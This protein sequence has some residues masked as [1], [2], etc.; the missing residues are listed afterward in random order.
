MELYGGCMVKFSFTGLLV[1]LLAAQPVLAEQFVVEL[2]EPSSGL[3][4]SI[5]GSDEVTVH[6]TLSGTS[7]TY[8]IFAA[9]DLRVLEQFL[10]S[11]DIAARKI[12]EVLFV[13]SPELG[14]A[15]PPGP[16]AR[17]GHQVFVIE[18]PIPGVGFF[19]IERKRQ[20]SRA[21]NAAIA[22]LGNVIEWQ[23]SYLTSDGTYCIYRADSTETLREHGA[24][25]GAPV[26]KITPV[27][28]RTH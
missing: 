7:G 21:S 3:L 8:A 12:S 14:G 11:E 27:I 23:K 25:A 22:V 13:N 4:R 6:E 17:E 5:V 1:G 10:R 15:D 19:G 16:L 2:L 9:P 20:I 26:G 18:R 28:Q 24:L